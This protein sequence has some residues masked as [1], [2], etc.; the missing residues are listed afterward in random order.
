MDKYVYA[1]SV[2]HMAL[3]PSR[4]CLS[5]TATYCARPESLRK[6]CSGPTPG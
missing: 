1:P 3:N 2:V 4:A 5:S 6:A